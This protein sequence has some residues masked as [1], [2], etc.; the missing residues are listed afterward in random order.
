MTFLSRR[1]ERAER[2]KPPSGSAPIRLGESR[3]EQERSHWALALVLFMRALAVVWM[4]QGLSSWAAIL[5]PSEPIFETFGVSF[6]VATAFFAVLDLVASVG[7][8]LATP[9]GGVLWLLS[10]IAQIGAVFAVPN[11]T[12]R[13]WI[14]GDVVLIVVYF[15]LT[16]QAGRPRDAGDGR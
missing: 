15:F 10:A 4:V 7:L 3:G 11:F 6:A 16:W 14:V 2:E 9:W 1:E 5:T 8:W 13:F 12:P